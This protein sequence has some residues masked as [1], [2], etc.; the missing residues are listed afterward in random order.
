M[1]ESSATTANPAFFRNCRAPLVASFAPSGRLTNLDLT[2]TARCG[3]ET[4]S[5]PLVIQ[6]LV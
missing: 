3:K 2:G 5:Q 1:R 4:L 6:P